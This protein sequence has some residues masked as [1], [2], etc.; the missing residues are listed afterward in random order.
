MV[1]HLQ[2]SN[3][4]YGLIGPNI[5]EKELIEVLRP[6]KEL[7]IVNHNLNSLIEKEKIFF[8]N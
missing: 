6:K 1:E 5:S 8:E 4:S 2:N 7:G 3:F